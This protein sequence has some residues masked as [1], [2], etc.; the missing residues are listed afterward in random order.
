L[1]LFTQATLAREC[2]CIVELGTY[3]VSEL[4]K[5]SQKRWWYLIK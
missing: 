1:R 5:Q 3:S 2:T 4:K